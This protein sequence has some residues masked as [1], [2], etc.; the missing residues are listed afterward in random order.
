LILLPDTQLDK[1]Q[2]AAEK[3]R[4]KVAAHEL[5]YQQQ[6]LNLTLS[7][8]VSEYQKDSTT[9]ACIKQADDCLY[10]AKEAG[11]NRVVV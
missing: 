4:Q 9:A 5:S 1:G 11:R 7:L 2:E 8:G 10:Q 3:L 6:K